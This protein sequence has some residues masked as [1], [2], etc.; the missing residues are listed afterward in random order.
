[1]VI[2]NVFSFFFLFSCNRDGEALIYD[3]Y[4]E[5]VL[6]LVWLSMTVDLTT[7]NLLLPSSSGQNGMTDEQKDNTTV[8]TKILDSLLD[9]YDN[10]LRPGLGGQY[11][12]VMGYISS[13]ITVFFPSNMQIQETS[14][15]SLLSERNVLKHNWLGC[16]SVFR[17][18]C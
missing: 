13:F 4:S 17:V 16:G 10:R 6:I 5:F 11:T 12:Q 7:L 3:S 2:Y 15:N 1:M 18:I 8:F 14:A 9:G